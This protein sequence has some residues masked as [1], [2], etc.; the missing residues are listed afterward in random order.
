MK[1]WAKMEQTELLH[2]RAKVM[3]GEMMP[4]IVLK[5]WRLGG[6]RLAYMHEN[7]TFLFADI[8]GFT[9][10]AKNVEASHVVATLTSLFALFDRETTL[11]GVFKVCTIGDAYVAITEPKEEETPALCKSEGQTN[12]ECN[13]KDEGN[14]AGV[15]VL[16]KGETTSQGSEKMICFAERL[17]MHIKDERERLQIPTLKMRVGLHFG[18]CVGGVIGSGR[19]RYDIWGPDVLTGTSIEQH[20]V[21]DE[22]CC[23]GVLKDFLIK[24]FDQKYEFEFLERFEVQGQIV[25]S[26]KVTDANLPPL[27]RRGSMLD[28]NK[29]N[30]Q[31]L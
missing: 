21:P 18:R 2:S 13:N 24:S 9:A 15:E 6:V 25:T 26:H 3:L 7:V 5:E 16:E 20:G 31:L 10:W 4:Q 29:Y 14:S 11:I 12:G 22:I 27:Q 8:C 19:L 30:K 23:S 1:A 28:T 17:L